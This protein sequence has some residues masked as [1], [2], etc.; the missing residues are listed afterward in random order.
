VKPLFLEVSG[1]GPFVGSQKINFEAF[2][3]NALFLIHGPTGGGKTFLF[4]A[5]CYALYADTPAGREGNLKSDFLPDNIEPFIDFRF[6]LGA[7]QYRVRR[8]L[9]Y[10]RPKKRGGGIHDE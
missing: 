1:I 2:G 4:D 3:D 5:I 7:K 6:S 9:A 8:N 10:R